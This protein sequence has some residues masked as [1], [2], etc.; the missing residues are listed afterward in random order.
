MS[1]QVAWD[2]A[3]QDVI[4][5]DFLDPWTVDE[6]RA[7]QETVNTWVLDPARPVEAM[8]V[9]LTDSGSLPQSVARFVASALDQRDKRH[10]LHVIPCYVIVGATRL[11]KSVF[12]SFVRV[13]GPTWL[14]NKVHFADD[15][16]AARTLI[17][18]GCG[19]GA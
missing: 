17:A 7:A 8:F 1:V 5:V 16:A 11:D 4:R 6:F 15:L 3:A 12:K 19:A 10:H 9:N 13:F 2:E 18:A 14:G